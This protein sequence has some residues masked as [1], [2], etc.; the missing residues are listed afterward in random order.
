MHKPSKKT[1]LLIGGLLVA[2]AL[3]GSSLAVY[4]YVREQYRYAMYSTVPAAEKADYAIVET[5]NTDTLVDSPSSVPPIL[6]NHPNL[7]IS[8][9][10]ISVPIVENVDTS[11]QRIYNT[12]LKSGVAQIKG[13]A[14][15]SAN[16]GNSAIIGH[17]SRFSPS[18]TPYDAIFATIPKLTS[19]DSIIVETPTSHQEFKV[20]DSKVI[21]ADDTEALKNSDDRELTLITCWPVGTPL[22][23]WEVR[24]VLV[25]D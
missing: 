5:D 6:P 10:G 23:R 21:S 14:G 13:T 16:T 17:S 8:K 3:T 19:G 22:K 2:I 24:A 18:G 12:A 4:P 15:L 11:L 1:L 25:T 9:L 20:T 7:I